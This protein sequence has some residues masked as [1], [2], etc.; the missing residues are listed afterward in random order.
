MTNVDVSGTALAGVYY[1]K[2][3]AGDLEGT[4]TG[5]SGAG[6]KFGSATSRDISWTG[7]DLTTNAVGIDA[8]GSGTITLIDSDFGNGKDVVIGGS[9]T[10]DFIEGTMDTSSVEVTGS[11]IL[12]RMRQIDI[13][14]EADSSAVSGANVVLTV[15]YT[16]LTLPTTD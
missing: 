6:I 10:V 14:V 12:N 13:S 9:S 2:D 7:M 8:D 11:G 5:S 16:H 4:I 15:S 1:I 3:L